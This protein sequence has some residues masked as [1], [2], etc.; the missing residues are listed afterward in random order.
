[1]CA[2]TSRPYLVRDPAVNTA[3]ARIDPEE[4][5]EAK[6]LAQRLVDDLDGDRHERP[7]AVADGSAGAAEAH[8]VIVG[9]IDIKDQLA[10]D[11]A[12]LGHG[13]VVLG[14]RRADAA[15]VDLDRHL[16]HKRRMQAARQGR[17]PLAGEAWGEAAVPG[18]SAGKARQ[19]ART[20]R[21]RLPPR[22][23]EALVA[24]V[25][26]LAV[27][28]AARERDLALEKVVLAVGRLV[29]ARAAV[30]LAP[31]RRGAVRGGGHVPSP[32]D[33]QRWNCLMGKSDL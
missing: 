22:V 12:E 19:I 6:V 25:D 7:A 16:L 3:T 23:A 21:C 30:S 28:R 15:N 32:Y 31:K 4:V 11:I 9:H 20:Q 29:C 33:S 2:S 14:R 24:L 13:V 5:L 8:V 26:L 10:L 17:R 18:K 1:M 27:R